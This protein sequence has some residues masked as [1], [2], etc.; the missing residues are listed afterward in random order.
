M[1][2]NFKKGYSSQCQEY[3]GA[4]TCEGKSESHFVLAA[5][6]PSTSTYSFEFVKIFPH[7]ELISILYV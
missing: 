3:H 1:P 5:F 4:L 7:Q 2:K 6:V